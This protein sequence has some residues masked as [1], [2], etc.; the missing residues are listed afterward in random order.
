MSTPDSDEEIVTFSVDLDLT[1]VGRLM[2][3][4]EVVCEAPQKIL[5]SL[6]TDILRDDAR[7]NGAE[8]IQHE[9]NPLH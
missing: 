2:A 8:S 5:A 7:E 3:L 6:L 1:T 4:A 9:G